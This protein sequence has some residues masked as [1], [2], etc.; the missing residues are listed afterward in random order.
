VFERERGKRESREKW[1]VLGVFFCS[2][3]IGG[4]RQ[5]RRRKKKENQKCV[6]VFLFYFVLVLSTF[7]HQ[8]VYTHSLCMAHIL[9]LP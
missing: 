9:T 8:H 6:G 1:G 5:Q 3:D 2:L 4:K 7:V